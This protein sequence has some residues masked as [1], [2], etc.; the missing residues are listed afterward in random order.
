ME[1]SENGREDSVYASTYLRQQ[2][3][4]LQQSQETVILHFDQFQTLPIVRK[5]D[6]LPPQPFHSVEALL[7][8]HDLL[9]EKALRLFVA[10]I[11]EEL[12]EAVVVEVLEAADVQDA[13]KERGEREGKKEEKW[14]KGKR[15]KRKE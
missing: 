12:L 4:L 15:E 2:G 10:E 9:D 11:D 13:W 3:L 6:A 7:L 14:R 8:R 1:E 5:R